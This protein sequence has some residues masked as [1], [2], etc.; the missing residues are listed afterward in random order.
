MTNKLEGSQLFQN[1]YFPEFQVQV[2][3]IPGYFKTQKSLDVN[4]CMYVY[5]YTL[6]I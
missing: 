5:M 3:W 1:K 4:K 2:Y 6:Y